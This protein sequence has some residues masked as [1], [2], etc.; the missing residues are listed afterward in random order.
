MYS[1]VEV[2]VCLVFF[3]VFYIYVGDGNRKNDEII[4]VFFVGIVFC[5]WFFYINFIFGWYRGNV[6]L[7]DIN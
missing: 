6:L 2:C 4:L 5:C 1:L 3:F 7:Y